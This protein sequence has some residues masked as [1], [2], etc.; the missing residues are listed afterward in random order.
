MK[1][2]SLG[3]SPEALLSKGRLAATTSGQRLPRLSHDARSHLP[4]KE[5][6]RGD[7]R[8]G[9]PRLRQILDRHKAR[10]HFRCCSCCFAAPWRL[11]AAKANE[12]PLPCR[13]SCQRNLE[14][15]SPFASPRPT[16]RF[17]SWHSP[18]LANLRHLADRRGRANNARTAAPGTGSLTPASRELPSLVADISFQ[19]T[20]VRG[21]TRELA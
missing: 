5:E 10:R 12:P 13:A 2:A 20:S 18:T 15:P 8:S 7:R 17:Y 4:T 11:P 19:V 3:K 16:P 14:E 1:G 21:M 6:N 9:P